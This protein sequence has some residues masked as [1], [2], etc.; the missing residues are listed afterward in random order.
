MEKC[1]QC[2]SNILTLKCYAQFCSSILCNDSVL[3]KVFSCLMINPVKVEAIIKAP[4]M[5][6]HFEKNIHYPLLS[7]KVI[8]VVS[9][10]K[11][12]HTKCHLQKPMEIFLFVFE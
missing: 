6:A 5:H 11:C 10:A 7:Y 1:C 12:H 3:E 4:E 8:N 9:L 2:V